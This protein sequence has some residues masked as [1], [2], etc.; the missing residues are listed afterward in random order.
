METALSVIT[1][2]YIRSNDILTAISENF[3]YLKPPV[4]DIFKSF[5]GDATAINLDIRASLTKLK[6]KI[7]NDIFREWIDA[8][9]QCQDDRTLSDTLLPI[10]N[11]LTDV[12]IVNNELKTMLYEPRKEYYMMVFLLVGNI[13]LLYLLNIDWFH[14]LILSLPG[15]NACHLRSGDPDY[16]M[17]YE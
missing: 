12:R 1:T 7:Y 15:N 4:R 11:K 17:V 16:G 3:Y 6:T 2:S 9:I 5:I 8:L 14:T 10:L 13:P